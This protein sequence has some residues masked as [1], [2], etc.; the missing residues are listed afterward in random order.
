MDQD[1]EDVLFCQELHPVPAGIK[2]SFS[3]VCKQVPQKTDY[4]DAGK[5]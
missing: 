5:E 3:T 1:Q 4:S 2:Q